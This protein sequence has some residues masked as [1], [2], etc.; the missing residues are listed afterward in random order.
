MGIESGAKKLWISLL[1]SLVLL[2]I[3]AGTGLGSTGNKTVPIYIKAMRLETFN[4]RNKIVFTGSVVAKRA[5]ATLYA[6]QM[7]VL[8]R[9]EEEKGQNKK[10]GHKEQVDVI[11]AQGHVKIVRG[12]RIATG[13]D[14]VYHDSEK[15]V[16]LTGNPRIWEGDNM[17]K[18]DKITVFLAEDRSIVESNAGNEVEAVIYSENGEK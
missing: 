6:D 1:I 3:S 9:K 18:G 7:T 12:N 10:S 8:Y 16:V 15:N 4:D 14:G 5:D 2:F 11:F 17:V 13:D